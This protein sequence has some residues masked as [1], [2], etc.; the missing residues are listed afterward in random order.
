[1]GEKIV[2]CLF[3]RKKNRLLWLFWK[4]FIQVQ[5]IDRRGFYNS[6]HIPFLLNEMPL[7]HRGKVKK[8]FLSRN[9]YDN[10]CFWYENSDRRNFSGLFSTTLTSPVLMLGLWTLWSSPLFERM[11]RVCSVE[12]LILNFHSKFYDAQMGWCVYDDIIGQKFWVPTMTIDEPN[13]PS[14][15]D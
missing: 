11:S 1:M 9:E 3:S 4:F 13:L 12:S 15:F 2:L 8:S 7:S 5:N 14:P 10:I 6:L